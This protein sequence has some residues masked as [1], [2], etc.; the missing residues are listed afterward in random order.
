VLWFANGLH[1]CSLIYLHQIR[2]YGYSICDDP[3]D[4]HRPLG[5]DLGSIF[6]SLT[7]S[8]PN[9]SFESRVPT[10]WEMSNLPIV[11]ITWTTWNPA[12]M[13]Q[14]AP[15]SNPTHVVNCISTARRDICSPSTA[16]Q[17]S[18]FPTSDSRC[19]SS[20]YANAVL[21]HDALTG[22]HG[23]TGGISAT[24]TSEQHSSV[25]FENLSCKWNISHE[26]AKQTLQSYNSARNKN[27]GSP[28]AQ[29]VSC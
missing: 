6:V 4:P 13:H 3:W 2:A 1:H 29:K 18:I 26:M 5:I 25:T 17:M 9:L 22:T 16:S 27:S 12:D 10:H 23:S 11:E 28:V 14:S 24:I 19:A 8:G 20:L 15:R 21:M 7:V